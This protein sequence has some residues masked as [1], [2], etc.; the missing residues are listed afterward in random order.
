MSVASCISDAGFPWPGGNHSIWQIMPGFWYSLAQ[1][2][3]GSVALGLSS[4]H[5]R[6]ALWWGLE[7]LRTNGRED[8]FV[9]SIRYYLP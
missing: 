3:Q 6:R 7:S 5:T 1:G 4:I 9:T 2:D 8:S